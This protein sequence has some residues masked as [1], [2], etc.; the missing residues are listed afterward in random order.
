[1]AMSRV[2]PPEEFRQA[3]GALADHR[4]MGHCMHNKGSLRVLNGPTQSLEVAHWARRLSPGL[5][6]ASLQVQLVFG[7]QFTMFRYRT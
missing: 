4:I 6:A 3:T 2:L 1:M 5:A 7:C